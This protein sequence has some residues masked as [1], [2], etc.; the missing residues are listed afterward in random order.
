MNIQRINITIEQLRQIPDHERALIVVLAHALNEVN[1][2]N[3]LLFLCTNFDIEPRWKAHAHASQAF[4]LARLLIG[5]LNEA[6]NAIQKGY[7]ASK[8]SKG[9]ANYLEPSAT[10]ALNDLKA[11]FGRKNLLYE[12]RNNFSFHYSLEHAATTIPDD[13]PTDD[14]TIFLHETQGNSLYY[15][16]EYL[17]SKA[18]ID[19]ISPND[20]ESALNNL[21]TEM[22]TVVNCLNEF[23]QGLLFVVLDNH[24][25]EDV[26][27]K[28]VKEIDLGIVARSIDVRIPYFFEIIRSSDVPIN[29]ALE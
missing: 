28:S 24:I 2:L 5:K 26:L 8:L 3:K 13:T 14:L 10:K 1:A 19:S 23:V 4:V 6:W 20:P 16:A 15:F 27:R 25:G 21:L 22:S 18:L 11:Y 7:F 12:V 17:M 9:Y 29:P